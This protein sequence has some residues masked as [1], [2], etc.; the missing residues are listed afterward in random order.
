MR[1]HRQ[2]IVKRRNEHVGRLFSGK[3]TGKLVDSHLDPPLPGTQASTVIRGCS[4]A[5]ATD[6][7]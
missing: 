7:I 1:R 6:D 5:K 3:V 2:P 4:L